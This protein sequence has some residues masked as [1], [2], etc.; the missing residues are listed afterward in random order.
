MDTLIVS[1]VLIQ[2]LKLIAGYGI[3]KSRIA[4]DMEQIILVGSNVLMIAIVIVFGYYL[5][6]VG[7]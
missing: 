3:I 7:K 4:L 5:V 2:M 6:K 1:E